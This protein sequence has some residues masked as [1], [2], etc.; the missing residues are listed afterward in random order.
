MQLTL[1]SIIE[2]RGIVM[3]LL[4]FIL[5][6]L[7]YDNCFG[8]N[9]HATTEDGKKVILKSDGSWEYS[10]FKSSFIDQKNYKIPKSSTKSLVL[11]GG[12]VSMFYNPKTWQQKK[13]DD[14]I[15]INFAQKDGDVYAMVIHE[16]MEMDI[17]ALTDF[18][19]SNARKAAPDLKVTVEEDRIVNGTKVIFMKM[20][21]SIQSIKFIYYAYYYT[22]KAGTLQ[23]ITYTY[24]NLFSENEK[25]MSDFLNGLVINE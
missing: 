4:L 2:L 21:G 17:D 6:F 5:L 22:G 3:K 13:S 19:I 7:V 20:E 11:N 10:S 1:Y 14:P 15:K 12:K 18:A 24:P 25:N 9:I 23:I 16:K 8:Q